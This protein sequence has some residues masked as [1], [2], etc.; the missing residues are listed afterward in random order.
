MIKLSI[1]I[2]II[3]AFVAGFMT[4]L[5]INRGGWIHY[6]PDLEDKEIIRFEFTDRTLNA[7]PSRKW[8]VFRII[9]HRK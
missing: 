1:A 2:L 6:H 8:Y 3:F 4:S 7:L 5:L 9:H